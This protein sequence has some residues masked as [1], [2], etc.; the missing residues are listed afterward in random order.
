MI[1]TQKTQNAI[2]K[3]EKII[4]KIKRIIE[5]FDNCIIQLKEERFK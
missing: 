2:I 3:R 5:F 4:N 1:K